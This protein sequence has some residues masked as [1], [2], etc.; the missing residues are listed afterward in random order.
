MAILLIN[1]SMRLQLN[2]KKCFLAHTGNFIVIY[3]QITNK[4]ILKSTIINFIITGVL[5]VVL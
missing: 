4:V 5:V 3:Y 1:I 2:S